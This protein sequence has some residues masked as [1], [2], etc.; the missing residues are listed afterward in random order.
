MTEAVLA[1]LGKLF[2]AE[3]AERVGR[4]AAAA[5]AG[6]RGGRGRRGGRP[7][8]AAASPA[9]ATGGARGE[10]THGGRWG[11]RTGKVSTTV[12]N[13]GRPS[14]GASGHPEM[15]KPQCFLGLFTTENIHS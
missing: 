4:T 12:Y 3:V 9:R 14:R 10:R 2:D 7:E 13:R 11:S 15:R 6:G 1:L 5:G 8:T